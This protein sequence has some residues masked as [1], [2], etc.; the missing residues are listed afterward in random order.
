MASILFSK[1][2]NCDLDS[3]IKCLDKDYYDIIEIMCY[4][5]TG[6]ADKL[7]E[8]G[9]HPST[10]L[11]TSM[12]I[13]LIEQVRHFVIS[14]KQVFLPYLAELDMKQKEKHNCSNCSGKCNVGHNMHLA[15]LKESPK[16]IKEILF[17]LQTVALPL[18]SEIEYTATY[19]MLRN[20]MMLLDTMLTE[21]FYLEESHL[22]PRVLDAQKNI[23]AYAN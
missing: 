22:I 10:S 9:I 4:S 12:A 14:R 21:L 16:K 20:E 23:H 2:R 7:N 17:R 18:Y 13:K 15:D 6:L 19:K 1:Y 8:E 11:Y 3:L 5:T